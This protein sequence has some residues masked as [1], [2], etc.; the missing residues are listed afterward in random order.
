M[1]ISKNRSCR[2]MSR[3]QETG[4]SDVETSEDLWLASFLPGYLGVSEE[5]HIYGLM[6]K[7]CLKKYYNS[8]ECRLKQMHIYYV[9][10]L[11][12]YLP[13]VSLQV[14]CRVVTGI[15]NS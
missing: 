5:T 7:T 4:V 1:Q 3:D 11:N 15:A 12:G 8:Y 10:P 13:C 14:C 9:M 6:K 2:L